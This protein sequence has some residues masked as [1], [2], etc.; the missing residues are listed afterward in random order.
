MVSPGCGPQKGACALFALVAGAYDNPVI[1]VIDEYFQDS[2]SLR[3]KV[4][5]AMV[6]KAPRALVWDTQFVRRCLRAADL[7]G[8]DDLKRML[9]ARQTAV[10]HGSAL[11]NTRRA[12]PGRHPAA[13]EGH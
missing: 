4:A 7:H 1:A 6:S 9:S 5:A 12:E 10:A 2:N 13:H 8:D 3:I 11:G